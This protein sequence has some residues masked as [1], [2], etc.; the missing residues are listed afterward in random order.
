MRRKN[1]VRSAAVGLAFVLVAAACG[2]DS[3]SDS[4]ATTAGAATTGAAADTTA[5]AADTTAAAGGETLQVDTAACP[6]EA[7][8]PLAEGE[9]IVI[10]ITVPLTGPLA[11]FG[12]IPQGMTVYFDKVNAAGGVDGHNVVLISKDDAYDPNKTPPLVTEL[13]E[14]DQMMAS[15]LQVGTPNVAATRALYEESC[16]PQLYVGTGFPAWGD[17]TAHQW[18]MGG[19]LAYNTEAVM[20]ADF[21]AEQKP[22]ATV[23]QLVFNNDFGKAYQTTFEAIAP[24]KGL[25]VVETQL[26]E[27]TATAIDNEITALLAANPDVIIGETTG[28]FCPRLFAG[29]AAGGFQGIVI[30]SATCASVAS[31]F[32]PVDP[33]GDGV[34]ILGQQ[35]DPSDPQF[36]EDPAMVEYKA[37]M[38]EFGE[39]LDPNN[40]QHLTGYNLAALMVDTLERATALEGGLTRANIMNA[41]WATN[42][43]VPLILGG[44]FHVDGITDAYGAEYAEML[45]YSAAEGSQVRTGLVF[46]VEGETGVYE[47]S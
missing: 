16:T 8:T 26:H 38:A 23:A 28:A 47:A 10:G 4:A 21:I 9:D 40:A 30:A 3:D 15:L 24:E 1:L 27:G 19:I 37:D 12:A 33:A 45:Q 36:A 25:E 46:D 34:Y 41:A 35:K 14:Q 20:W 11:A 17:P 31:F 2:D 42:F 5:A 22:G 32:T 43:E 44:T 13:I 29:L 39:S 6:P 7:T 18:T